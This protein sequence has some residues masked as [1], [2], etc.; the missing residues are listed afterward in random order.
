MCRSCDEIAV[1]A[2]AELQR[3]GRHVRILRLGK[4]PRQRLHA[5]VE[6][7]GQPAAVAQPAILDFRIQ[8]M[9]DLSG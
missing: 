1:F 6:Y 5:Q 3:A 9:S 2:L 8:H 4:H 7:R